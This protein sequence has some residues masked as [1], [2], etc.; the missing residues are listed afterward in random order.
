MLALLLGRARCLCAD[1]NPVTE[2]LGHLGYVLIM[3]SN[4]LGFLFENMSP[5]DTVKLAS[6]LTGPELVNALC[7]LEEGSWM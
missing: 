4:S 6:G 3:G 7:R 5:S 2:S 1:F